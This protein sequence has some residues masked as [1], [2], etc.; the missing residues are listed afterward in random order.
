M[1]AGIVVFDVVIVPDRDPRT[2][3]V[4]LL[5]RRVGLVPGVHQAIVGQRLGDVEGDV[6]HLLLG[7]GGT[8]GGSLVD[9]VPEV[10]HKIEIFLGHPTVGGPVSVHPMLARSGRKPQARHLLSQRGRGPGPAG[11]ALVASGAK[12]VP[13]GASRLQTAHFDMHGMTKLRHR[14]GDAGSRDILKAF[15]AGQF[16]DHLDGGLA[17][18]AIRRERIAN[19]P[20]PQ[21]DAVGPWISGSDTELEE[22]AGIRPSLVHAERC[23]QTNP[24]RPGEHVAARIRRHGW[25]PPMSGTRPE[26]ASSIR[27][28]EGCQRPRCGTNRFSDPNR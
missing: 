9:V 12:A 10:Q 13:I 19:Q 23:R 16:P 8:R 7:C 27:V 25:F 26:A 6:A 2:G 20:R 22:A 4:R 17:H 28:P 15:V 11:R 5:D 21:D 3:S 18:A 14:Q 1:I 24:G